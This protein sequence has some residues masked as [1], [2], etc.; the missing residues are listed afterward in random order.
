MRDFELRIPCS[1]FAA[2]SCFQSLSLAPTLVSVA[3]MVRQVIE[4]GMGA[5]PCSVGLRIWSSHK[6]GYQNQENTRLNACL[7]IYIHIYIRI[8]M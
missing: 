1:Q 3:R 8:Y 7:M 5:G 2:S 6:L 4:R